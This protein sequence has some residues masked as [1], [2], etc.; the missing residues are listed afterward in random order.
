[1]SHPNPIPRVVDLPA[2]FAGVPAFASSFR[3]KADS[4][5]SHCQL[6]DFHAAITLT[7]PTRFR[8]APQPATVHPAPR[9]ISSASSAETDGIL[10]DNQPRPSGNL[11]DDLF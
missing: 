3:L 4:N 1:L 11:N 9:S 10:K 2:L 8:I 5:E 7:P 6:A